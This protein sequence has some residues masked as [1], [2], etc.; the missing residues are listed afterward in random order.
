MIIQIL[1]VLVLCAI[2]FMAIVIGETTDVFNG[3]NNDE[4]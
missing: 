2:A 4:P 1:T 3:G